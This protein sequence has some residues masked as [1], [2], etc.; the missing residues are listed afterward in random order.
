ML[1]RFDHVAAL[2]RTLQ[3]LNIYEQNSLPLLPLQRRDAKIPDQSTIQQ[4]SR[5]MELYL[6]Q[7][8][9]LDPPPLEIEEVQ[10]FFSNSEADTEEQQ[11]HSALD[12]IPNAFAATS[13][14]SM[15]VSTVI[16]L[17]PK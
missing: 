14:V 2:H 17:P 15:L 13:L 11:E 5:A 6:R 7:L 3:M 4:Q 9:T 8:S 16:A 12:L 10:E 1:K